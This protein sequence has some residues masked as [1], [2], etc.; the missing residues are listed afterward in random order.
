MVIGTFGGVY[1][2]WLKFAAGANLSNTAL[3]LFAVFMVMIGVQF[4]ISGI[5][6]DIGIKG[7]QH[8][9]N[10]EPYRVQKVLK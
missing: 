4:F 1:S 2:A 7:Y 10:E 5:F 8:A 9:K 6:A 3:P